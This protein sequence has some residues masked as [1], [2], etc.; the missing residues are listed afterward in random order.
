MINLV[1]TVTSSAFSIAG[2]RFASILLDFIAIVCANQYIYY[3]Y[4]SS[5]HM[6]DFQM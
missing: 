2:V 6:A 5:N 4:H 1:D 3:S